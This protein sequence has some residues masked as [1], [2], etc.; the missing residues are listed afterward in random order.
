MWQEI[1]PSPQTECP[2]AQRAHL[3]LLPRRATALLGPRPHLVPDIGDGPFFRR[4]ALK[5]T[6]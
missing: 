1:P 6:H 2:G 4:A 5:K 3:W